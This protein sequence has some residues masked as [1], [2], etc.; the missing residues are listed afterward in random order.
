[1]LGNIHQGQP[2]L[3]PIL[4]IPPKQPLVYVVW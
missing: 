2:Y 1:M 3:R 4:E